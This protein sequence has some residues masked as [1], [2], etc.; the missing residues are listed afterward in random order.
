MAQEV[1]ARIYATAGLERE[2]AP[3]YISAPR[4]ILHDRARREGVRAAWREEAI[5]QNEIA[6]ESRD[7]ERV[8]AGQQALGAIQR[9]LN[10]LPERTRVIFILYRL[11]AMPARRSPKASA[12]RSAP[13]KSISPRP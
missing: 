7:P 12:S 6:V 3:A 4:P 11:E 5:T 8:L 10:S 13:W 1:L 9:A 2:T